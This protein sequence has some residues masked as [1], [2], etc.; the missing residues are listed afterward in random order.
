[1]LEHHLPVPEDYVIV[2]DHMEE[3]GDKTGYEGDAEAAG[4]EGTS[5]GGLLLQ[6]SD[7]AIGAIEATSAAGLRVPDDI[8]II[9]C[10][11]MPYND[12][13]RIPLSSIDHGTA[14]LGR[15][16]AGEPALELVGL[17]RSSRRR[18]FLFRPAQCASPPPANPR[19]GDRFPSRRKGRHAQP[20]RKGANR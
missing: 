6:R 12:Y 17:T 14:E 18:V 13:L 1:M 16:A 20:M 15:L 2:C 10:G 19:A 9:G 8:A 4:P 3:R 11:N 5:G 7:R